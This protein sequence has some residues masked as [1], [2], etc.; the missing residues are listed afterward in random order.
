MEPP[1]AGG[2]PQSVTHQ[3]TQ[4][5][6]PVSPCR[7]LWLNVSHAVGP[8]TGKIACCVF[9]SEYLHEGIRANMLAEVQSDRSFHM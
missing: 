8:Y 4:T 3:A 7:L 5:P 1:L 2:E 9:S 6:G